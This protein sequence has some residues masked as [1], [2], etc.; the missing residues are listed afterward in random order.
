MD[1]HLERLVRRLGDVDR[2]DGEPLAG[3]H[4][5]ECT[6]RFQPRQRRLSASL[7]ML[8]RSIGAAYP[9][10]DLLHVGRCRYRP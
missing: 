10:Q 5:M 4:P 3:T 9:P 7:R 6:L 1:D 2:D 8:A